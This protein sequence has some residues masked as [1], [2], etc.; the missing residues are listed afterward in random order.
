MRSCVLGGEFLPFEVNRAL[1]LRG[2]N[3]T[4][5][6][7]LVAQ[8]L[9]TW[10]RLVSTSSVLIV[11]QFGNGRLGKTSLFGSGRVALDF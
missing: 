5:I 9:L 11:G 3:A 1:I 7:S 4:C 6:K 8:N 10:Q 2:K